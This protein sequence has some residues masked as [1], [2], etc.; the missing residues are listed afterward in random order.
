M[1]EKMTFRQWVE[2]F[3][4]HNKVAFLLIVFFAVFLGICVAQLINK[5]KPDANFLYMGPARVAFSGESL[6]QESMATVMK[7]DYNKDGKKYIDYI[8]LTALDATDDFDDTEGDFATGY[9]GMKVQKTVGDAF[10]AQMIAGDSMIYL[11]DEK[12]FSVAERTGVLMPLSEALGYTPDF[13]VNEYAVYLS[14]LDVSYLPGLS[15]IPKS[16]LICV[17]YPVTIT[18][19]KEE[20]EL[21][22]KCNLNVFRDMFSFVYENKP[23]PEEVIPPTALSIDEFRE[24]LRVYA[25]KNSLNI[26]D[27][28]YDRISS[29]TPE[30]FFDECG[31]NLFRVGKGTYL[32][33]YGE[34]FSLGR[35]LGGEGVQDIKYKDVTGDGKPEVIFTYSFEESG[36]II[37]SASVFNLETKKEAFLSLSSPTPLE[38][39]LTDGED[40]FE[41]YTDGSLAYTVTASE[42]KYLVIIE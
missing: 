1:K 26:T 41:L 30:G 35:Y 19:G 24:L 29:L 5:N 34:V 20:V 38:V 16:T 14:D 11:L 27:E 10:T 39:V 21:R 6:I 25:S 36:K 13:A 8:E 4:Y 31:A 9:D 3:W 17:R 15:L 33:Y 37:Y 22:E 32:T 2:N 12:Y 7:E 18:N 23:K 28:E 42:G 40:S